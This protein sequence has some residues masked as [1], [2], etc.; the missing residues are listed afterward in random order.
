[1]ATFGEREQAVLLEF[2]LQR[3]TADAE[4]TGGEFAIGGDVEKRLADEFL[5]H[6]VDRQAG[7]YGELGLRDGDLVVRDRVICACSRNGS[8]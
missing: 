7:V 1:V 4:G 3:A 2:V 6:G 8:C 5:F